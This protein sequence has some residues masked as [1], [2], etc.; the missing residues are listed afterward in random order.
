MEGVVEAHQAVVGRASQ[1]I[2]HLL[3]LR[4]RDQVGIKPDKVGIN[5][6]RD[7]ARKNRIRSE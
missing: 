5:T 6:V 2:R 4:D 3:L 1:F 7:Q